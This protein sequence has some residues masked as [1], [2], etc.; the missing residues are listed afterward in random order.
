MRYAFLTA[1]KYEGNNELEMLL[2]NIK[3]ILRVKYGENCIE[4]CYNW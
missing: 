4:E 3:R 2:H 1:R